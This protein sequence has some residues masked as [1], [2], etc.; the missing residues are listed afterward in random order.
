MVC[1]SAGLL[2]GCLC[3]VVW[4]S[5]CFFWRLICCC[6]CGCLGTSVYCGVGIIQYL[7]GFGFGRFLVVFGLGSV[8]VVWC[9][10]FPGGFWVWLP[11]ACVRG[12][13][14]WLCRWISVRLVLG[15]VGASV[16]FSGLLL[17][18]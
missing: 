11:A 13:G 7:L 16:G 6:V 9:F 12:F 17:G 8:V 1:C 2:L 15:L 5:F 14:W 10:E 3:W 18:V 4:F